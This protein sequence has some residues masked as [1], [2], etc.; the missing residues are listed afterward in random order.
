MRSAGCIALRALATSYIST[1]SP[2]APSLLPLCFRALEDE[3]WAI[4]AD[5]AQALA[6]IAKGMGSGVVEQVRGAQHC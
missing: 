3:S 1:I 5:A 6:A 2:H 4:R